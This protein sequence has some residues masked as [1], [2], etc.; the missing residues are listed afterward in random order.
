MTQRN[1]LAHLSVATILLLSVPLFGQEAGKP[2]ISVQDVMGNVEEQ[3][4]IP[5]ELDGLGD[6]DVLRIELQVQIPTDILDFVEVRSRLSGDGLKVEASLETSGGDQSKV[7]HLTIQIDSTQ[8]L[9]PGTPVEMVFDPS[10]KIFENM[11]FY[12]GIVE[13]SLETAEGEK[14]QNVEVKDGKVVIIIPTFA[15]FFY[16]H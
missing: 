2:V 4:V 15:C 3:V 7:A 1:T 11:E 9:V 13:V 16:M 8:P 6:Q 10:E 14:I 5:I 12:L